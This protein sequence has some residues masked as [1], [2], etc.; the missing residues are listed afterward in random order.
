MPG[1]G[2]GGVDGGVALEVGGVQVGFLRLSRARLPGAGFRLGMVVQAS[3]L[4]RCGL[5]GG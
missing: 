4:V 3:V 1:S 5:K 2:G